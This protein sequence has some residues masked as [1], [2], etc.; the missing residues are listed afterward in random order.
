MHAA[1]REEVREVEITVEPLR[2]IS[3]QIP[4]IENGATPPFCTRTCRAEKLY[5]IS[6]RIGCASPYLEL[7]A[8]SDRMHSRRSKRILD[9]LVPAID[10]G[11]VDLP[12]LGARKT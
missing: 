5:T 12:T 11:V 2:Y 6:V 3:Q 4:M 10:V 1:P 9:I 8:H 7:F